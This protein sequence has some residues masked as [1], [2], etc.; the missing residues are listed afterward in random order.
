MFLKTLLKQNTKLVDAAILFWHQG[1]ISPDSYVI[2]VEQ[3]ETNARLLLKTAHHCQIKLYLMSKQFGRNPELCRR[4]LACRYEGTGYQG[5]VAVDFKEARLL[6]HHQIPVAHIGHLVQPPS[7]MVA[8]IVRRQ[9]EVITVFSLEKALEISQAAHQQ[10]ITQS[11]MLKVCQAGDL[12]YAGQEAG[13]ELSH[14]SAVIA[15][16]RKLPAVRLVGI[17]HFPCML[18]DPPSHQTLPTANMR[19]LLAARDI[20]LAEGVDI[21]QVN[22]P[23]ATSCTTLPQLAQ[24][25]VTHAEP[26]HA[27]TGTIPA[28]QQGDQPEQISMLYLSEISHHFSGNSYFYGGG[29]Y[30]RGH[31]QN[32]LIHHDNQFSQSSLLPI[33]ESSID[34]CLGLA[35]EFPVG[36]PVIMSFRT[37]IFA[38]RSDV[39]LID[40]IQRGEPRLLGCYDSRGTQLS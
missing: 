1:K 6:Y 23:S 21:E 27:L 30:R 40:G 22:A 19:T 26:G 13:F 34:Y 29:Y 17:T 33:D 3:T 7:G 38:T 20:L 18:Y 32:A 15:A 4:L 24:W 11:L 37:Q 16:I 9:P 35:G 36:S 5:M 8:E 39:V 10:H 12:L 2:D 28:N 14:L 25:G 31:L